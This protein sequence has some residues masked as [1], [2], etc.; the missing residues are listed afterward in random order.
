ME[1]LV[2]MQII[3]RLFHKNPK[4]LSH[5]LSATNLPLKILSSGSQSQ[6]NAVEELPNAMKCT[7]L[8]VVY[9]SQIHYGSRSC[10]PISLMSFQGKCDNANYTKNKPTPESFQPNQARLQCDAMQCNALQ[11][12]AM[13]CTALDAH[14]RM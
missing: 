4:E 2:F 6:L 10:R 12:N 3:C 9:F 13:Q 5:N 7:D 14:H 1:H 8:E 11:C